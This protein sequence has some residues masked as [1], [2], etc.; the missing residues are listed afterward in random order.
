M[1]LKFPE[2]LPSPF[3]LL[4]LDYNCWGSKRKNICLRI[5]FRTSTLNFVLLCRSVSK[6]LVASPWNQ[7]TPPQKKY[8]TQHS[9]FLSFLSTNTIL[10]ISLCIQRGF[11][12]AGFFLTFFSLVKLSNRIIMSYLSLL[13]NY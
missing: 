10:L 7:Q 2:N 5:V 9:V 1:L 3:S 8:W 4:L 12:F 13:Q 11:K 6:L